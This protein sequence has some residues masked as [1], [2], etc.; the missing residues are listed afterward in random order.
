MIFRA[1]FW[2]HKIIPAI[3]LIMLIDAAML[4]SVIAQPKEEIPPEGEMSQTI[5]EDAVLRFMRGVILTEAGKLDNAI[6]ELKMA[7]LFDEKSVYLKLYL[8]RMYMS[9]GYKNH[10]RIWLEKVL[11]TDP[12]N[13]EALAIL[14]ELQ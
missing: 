5:S 3:F 7:I 11:Q 9:G 6:V 12:R 14:R 4:R 13:E 1:T 8:A 2:S 10:A